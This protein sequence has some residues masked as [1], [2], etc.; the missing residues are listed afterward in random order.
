MNIRFKIVL[1]IF[2]VISSFTGLD[3]LFQKTIIYPSFLQLEEQ[4]G[5]RNI[6]RSLDAIKREVHHL[7]LL[8]FDWSAWDDTYTFIIDRNSEYVESNLVTSTFTGSNLDLILFFNQNKELVWG[9]RFDSKKEELIKWTGRID[10]DIPLLNH[11]DP[12]QSISGIMMTKRGPYIIASRPILTSDAKG[13]IHGSLIMGRHLDEKALNT[14]AEQTSVPFKVWPAKK[15]E[16]PKN[17]QRQLQK[18]ISMKSSFLQQSGDDLLYGYALIMD[19]HGKPALMLRAET[20]RDISAHGLKAMEMATLSILISGLIVLLVLLFLLKLIIADPI[21][22]L[23]DHVTDIGNDADLS[24]RILMERS[25]EIGT[26][27]QAFDALLEQ[28]SESRKRLLEQSYQSGIAELASGTLHN[29]RNALVPVV[30]ETQMLITELRK[31]PLNDYKKV[32]EALA[33]ELVEPK[34]RQDLE[35]FRGMVLDQFPPLVESSLQRLELVSKSMSHVETVLTVDKHFSTTVLLEKFT[36]VELINDACSLAI[37]NGDFEVNYIVDKGI[38]EVDPINGQRIVLMQILAN[39]IQNGQESI[40][41]SNSAVGEIHFKVSSKEGDAQKEVHLTVCDN[42]VGLDSGCLEDI[43][44]RDTTT[45]AGGLS[46]T[47]LHW[48]ANMMN[49]MGGRIWAESQ[50]MGACIHLL[51][52]ITCESNHG[53]LNGARVE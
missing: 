2:L 14:L 32:E 48:C 30:S 43:F 34:R 44:N 31:G 5:Q 8:T 3:F 19:I 41:N 42:G 33:I 49:S 10:Q 51:I 4:E 36:L 40:K 13:P 7:D 26:L 12:K 23:A 53:V 17:E 1:I 47:G 52:P 37:K 22:K 11:K 27:A 25:D 16:V 45:K 18:L 9:H 20:K 35:R 46:G 29:V 28:I 39:L 24:K 6:K 50:Q 38:S 15:S 21:T